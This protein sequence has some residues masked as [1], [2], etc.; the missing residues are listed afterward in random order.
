MMKTRTTL[1]T[2]A[3]WITAAAVA[4]AASAHMGTW[5]L[6]EAK[7]KLQSGNKNLTVT[8]AAAKKDMVKLTSDGMNKEGKATHWSWVGKFDGKAYKVKGDYPADMM[9]IQMVDDHTNKIT[10]SKDGKTMFTSTVTVAKDG[11]SR[12]VVTNGTDAKGKKWTDKAYYD[13][14]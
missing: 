14:Q 9:A 11:K 8:Y 5:K 13:K 3:L 12:M 4:F 7:S 2:A 10:A 1:V 6:N